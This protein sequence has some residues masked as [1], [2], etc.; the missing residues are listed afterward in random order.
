MVELNDFIVLLPCVAALVVG[1]LVKNTISVIPNKYIPLICGVIGL[2]VNI[3]INWSF[4]PEI[5][6]SG[7]VSG[8]AATGMFELVR[9]LIGGKTNEEE[10]K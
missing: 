2:L 10:S 3:W 9:N 7:L 5:L 4:S 6:V 1:F 8:V